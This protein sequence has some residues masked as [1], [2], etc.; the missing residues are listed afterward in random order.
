MLLG[1][2]HHTIITQCVGYNTVCNPCR[3]FVTLFSGLKHNKF[4]L[5]LLSHFPGPLVNTNAVLITLF[6][7][8]KLRI[9]T[10]PVKLLVHCTSVCNNSK[11]ALILIYFSLRSIY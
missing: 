9:I 4:F 7:N 8:L 1:H 2:S 11:L 5:K 6:S 10:F 3:I